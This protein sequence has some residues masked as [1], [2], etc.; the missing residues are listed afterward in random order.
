MQYKMFVLLCSY[1][2]KMP[3]TWDIYKLLDKHAQWNTVCKYNFGTGLILGYSGYYI[4]ANITKYLRDT[5]RYHNRNIDRYK[6]IGWVL[7]TSRQGLV[8]FS[9]LMAVSWGFE[10]KFQTRWLFI[11]DFLRRSNWSKFF[12]VLYHFCSFCV[13]WKNINELP[14]SVCVA[15]VLT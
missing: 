7:F 6:R 10:L 5:L 3:K 12:S 2:H 15:G 13:F 8:L 4:H 9:S 11:F 1:S 14:Y